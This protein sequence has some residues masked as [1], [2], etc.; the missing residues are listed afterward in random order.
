MANRTAQTGWLQTIFLLLR[1][2]EVACS[3]IFFAE[4]AH[5]TRGLSDIRR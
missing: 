5:N 4:N 3:G 1:I 2:P